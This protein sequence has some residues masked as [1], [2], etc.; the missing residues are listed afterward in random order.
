MQGSSHTTTK[1]DHTIILTVVRV[2]HKPPHT[3]PNHQPRQRWRAEG[4]SLC[5]I[6]PKLMIAIVWRKFTT[7]LD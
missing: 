2:A 1:R 4:A 3:T 7:R 6:T 5:R